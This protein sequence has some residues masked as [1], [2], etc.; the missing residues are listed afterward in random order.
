MEDSL[1]WSGLYLLDFLGRGESFS[2]GGHTGMLA[3]ATVLQGMLVWEE[4][5]VRL[6]IMS[7]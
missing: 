4:T 3:R 5:I 6:D 1:D 2:V 7:P